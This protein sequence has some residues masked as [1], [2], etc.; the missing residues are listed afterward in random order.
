MAV[1]LYRLSWVFGFLVV[2]GS[3]SV[4]A[5]QDGDEKTPEDTGEVVAPVFY[6]APGTPQ[7]ESPA[8]SQ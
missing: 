3:S 1:H 4:V 6:D 8:E 2:F 7:P 5:A